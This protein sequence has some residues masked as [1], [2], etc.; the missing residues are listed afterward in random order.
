VVSSPGIFYNMKVAVITGGSSGIGKEICSLFS[1]KRDVV[2]C[3]DFNENPDVNLSLMIDVGN[4]KSVYEAVDKIIREYGRIDIWIN[5]AGISHI[6][7]VEHTSIEDIDR[8]YHTNIKG[9]YNGCLAAIGVMKLQYAGVI[10]NMGSVA[11]EV[12]LSDRFAYS[13]S[14]G[15]VH[16]MTFSIAKDYLKY[17]IRC[18]AIAPARVHTAFVDDYLK[19]NYPGTEK[20]MFDVLSATQPI[21]RMG[22]P[23]EVADLS[24]FLCS[25]AASFITG[26]IF[27]IDGGF[28]KLNT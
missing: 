11:A 25:D 6:G 18:N 27:P 15:A 1:S 10:L 8:I 17:N 3:L 16:A 26:S 19:K 12:G 7:N 22:T 5:N 13:M 4:Q 21:G 14:K 9:V 20:E 2:V 23:K 24:Y 28:L